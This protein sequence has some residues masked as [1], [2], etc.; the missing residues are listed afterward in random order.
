MK[1]FVISKKNFLYWDSHVVDAFK[2]LNHD[3]LHFQVNNR[4]LDSQIIRGLCK[5]LLGKNIGSKISNTYLINKLKKDLDK[6]QP[7][8]IFVPYAFFVPVEFYELF[9]TLKSKPK[10]FA[11]E[12]DGGSDVDLNS[13]YQPYIDV[14][15]ETDKDYVKENK[16]GFK[17]IVHLPFCSNTFRYKDLSLNKVNKNYF[18]GNLAH[19]R[20]EI[21]SNLTSFDFVLK[22]WNWDKLSKK[23]ENFIIKHGTVDIDQQIYDYNT[24]ISV[25]N[26]H[27]KV[28]HISALNMRT[29]EVPSCNT[30]LINDYR[31]GLED[32]FELNKEILVFNTLEDLIEI[33]NRL[34]K[35]PRFY[36][37]VSENG[38]KRV[39]AEHKYID[40]M[41][42]VLE[43]L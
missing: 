13:K 3:V 35:E 18:C 15:F 36:A 29:F 37:K 39:H 32:L 33:L 21:F 28:N 38:Y 40:R 31:D 27:Q 23:S 22:G 5:G 24:Y 25:L 9:T 34:K 16:L 7:D 10:I 42:K 2:Y 30:L 14:L 4:T 26:I 41:K 20:D 11:W 6:F 17:E 43:F 19:G 12:G 1:I 8:L